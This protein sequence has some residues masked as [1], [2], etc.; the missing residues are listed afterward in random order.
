MYRFAAQ[1]LLSRPVRSLLA[2]LGLTVAITGMVGLFSIASGIDDT[3]SQTFGRIRG[4]AV[5]QPGAPIPLFS[6]LPASWADE[7]AQQKGVGVVRPEVWV[8]AQLVEGKPTF[9]PPRFLFGTD[10]ERTL[11]L[12][13]A[14]YRDDIRSGRFLNLEDRGTFHCVVS[15]SIADALHKKV[16]DPLR[17]DGHDLTIVGIYH[18][19]SLLLDVAIVLDGAT[20]R[21]IGN[22]EENLVTSIY[23]EPDGTVPNAKLIEQL[24][25]LFRGRKT[26]AW[27]T[28][29]LAALAG[30]GSLDLMSVAVKLL[31]ATPASPHEAA[32]SEKPRDAANNN[33]ETTAALEETVEIRSAQDWGEKISELSGDLDIFLG[34]MT[35]IGVLI[36]LLSI[37]NTMLMSVAERMIEFGVL[38]ANG[39]SSW[40]VLRLITWESALLGIMGGVLGCASGYVVV[41][42]V[43]WTFPT[44][45][46]LF[47]SPSLLLFS[48]VFST[49][50]GMSG[51]LYPAFWA[52]RMSPME[53]IRRG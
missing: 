2:L 37:L 18:C 27:R 11:A 23:F 13:E 38:R 45:V 44:K 41:Q 51:G 35:A 48:L 24:Q 52:V 53:A 14:V 40:D 19:G 7:I 25:A 20:A 50:L 12:K 43:N 39:W 42:V 15:Q 3:V 34:L 8:R 22:F 17:V 5:M 31:Q 21:T 47:A 29:G 4:L 49:L 30:G 32:G 46:H 33:A 1:N 26:D 16:G 6:R 9:T 28:G 36:A 10:I